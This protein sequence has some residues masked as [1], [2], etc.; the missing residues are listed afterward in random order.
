MKVLV[1]VPL[2]QRRHHVLF[3]VAIKFVA[4]FHDFAGS[5][6]FFFFSAA[7][8]FSPRPSNRTLEIWIVPSR[9]VILPVGLSCDLRRCFLLIR[10][11][12]ISNCCLRGIICIIRPDD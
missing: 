2:P 8:G 11:L 9:S 3:V 4:L 12:S 1:T 10:T 6:S 5:F 7:A